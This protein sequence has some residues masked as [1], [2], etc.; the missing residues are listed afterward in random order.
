MP[1]SQRFQA[2]VFDLDGLLFNTEE[3]Y[4]FVGVELL[5][6][7]GKDFPPELLQ[8]IMGRPQ[9]VALQLM[10]D[11]HALDATV[12]ILLAETE[13]VFAEILDERLEFM[14]GAKAL[15]AAL[16]TAGIPKA[17]ATSSGRKFTRNILGRF[18]LEPRFAFV[19]TCENV[20]HGKPHPEIYLQAAQQFGIPPAEMMVFED[21]QNGCRA[22]V[23]AGA[24]AVAVPNGPS[25]QHDFTGAA[26]IADSL[27]DPRIYTALQISPS[28]Q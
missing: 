6:R 14:P 28:Q 9:P 18:Q 1:S 20:T 4:N 11:W 24:F 16:E 12:E 2:V 8:Q 10:I 26:L 17:I 5:G 3:L 19:L 15:L 13:V 22:A 25:A 27:T 21:S 23:A 7:R